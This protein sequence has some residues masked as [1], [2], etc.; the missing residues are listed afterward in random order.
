MT[1]EDIKIKYVLPWLKES[2]VKPNEIQLERSF[3]LKIGRQS[4]PIG[5]K[6]RK[7]NSVGGRLDILVQ[8]NGRNLLIVE[9]KADGLRLTDD[10]R[11]QA[12]S[13]ARLVH[14]VAPYAL[15]TNGQTYKL[16]DSVT[17]DLID[18]KEI[19]IRGFQATLP[20]KDI[21]E[22]QSLFLALNPSNLLAFCRTQVAGELRIIKGSLE[23]DRKYIPELHVPRAN[24]SEEINKFYKLPLP[25][26]LLTGHSGSGKTCEMCWIAERLLNSGKPVLFFNGIALEAGI[27]DAISAEFAWTFTGSDLPIQVVQRMAKLAGSERLTIVLDAIDEWTYSS[28]ENNLGSL[29]RAAENNNVKIILSCKT[30]AITQFISARG[31]QTNIGLLTKTVET[32]KFSDREFCTAIENYRQA[33][34]FFGGFEDTVFDEARNNPFLLRV[35]FDVAKNS[36]LKHIT[37]SSAEFFETYFNR[38]ISRT[39]VRQAEDTLKAIADFLYQSNADWA[40]EEEI[41]KLLGLR[42]TE[43]IMEELFE[44]GIILR[45]VNKSGITVGF[46]FQQLRD[47]IV[48]FK[49]RRFGAMSQQE[50]RNEFE[51]ITTLGTRADVFTL[52]Y[53][54]A[55]IEHKIIL[56]SDVRKNAAS[57]LIAYTSL[58]QQNFPALREIF[59]PQ[60]EGR[61][62]FI[63]ELLLVNRRLGG[64]GFRALGENDDEVHFV[65]VQKAIGKSN[66]SYLYGANELH[67]TGSSRGFKDG[68]DISEEVINHE[69]FPQLENFLKEGT[70]NESQCPEMLS[71][72]VIETII[73]NKKIFSQLFDATTKSIKYPIHLDMILESLLRERLARYYRDALILEK[74]QSGE[75]KEKWDG[76]FVSYSA[77]LTEDDDNKISEAIDDSLSSGR[78]P[79][80]RIRYTELEALESSLVKAINQLRPIQTKIDGPLYDGES[81]LKANT[82]SGQPLPIDDANIY[83]NWLYSA[84]LRN[85]KLIIETNFPT[86]KK[87]F[88]LYS[89]L[90][91]QVHLLLG[92]SVKQSFGRNLTSLD[93]YFS[94]SQSGDIEVKVVENLTLSPDDHFSI[95]VNGVVFETFFWQWRSFEILFSGNSGRMNDP[96]YGMTLRRLVYETI[97]KEWK[98]AQKKIKQLL[99]T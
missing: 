43:P 82:Y 89:T 79:T 90:P 61:V 58:I 26:L 17:K 48:A 24:I 33:Y 28:R 2:G 35:I 68:I 94:S 64:Y 27:I 49:A 3:S 62:G 60:T 76:G 40:P 16:Y 99:N 20:D 11:D 84:F 1:E 38:S 13:Y 88:N 10:D 73:K 80:F 71:E 44:Y 9:T 34:Q 83:L 23:N 6:T 14:P 18:P 56:D 51:Q 15:V 41:R 32:G 25:G 91:V 21:S 66:I 5:K 19:Q 86:T 59:K 92:K 65:P 57:Y 87:Y 31:N 53:R 36:N 12:I 45:S 7:S 78:L 98:T 70:L 42:V 52:Y 39:D 96:F 95:N 97:E 8:R 30:S 22:A 72:F 69:I 63:G 55:S 50:L 37:F 54:L 4:I 85:Y 74:R 29:L 46:Y 47:Y 75:I 67:L 93:T 77:N 81:K